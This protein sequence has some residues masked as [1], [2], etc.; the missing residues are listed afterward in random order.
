MISRSGLG[1]G[2]DTMSLTETVVPCCVQRHRLDRP[3]VAA[4]KRRSHEIHRSRNAHGLLDSS[5][6]RAMT[7]RI[8]VWRHARFR[9]AR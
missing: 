1:A 8:A 2:L 5:M 7:L 4:R 9:P 6:R 3:G